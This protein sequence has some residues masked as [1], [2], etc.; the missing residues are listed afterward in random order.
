MP[1]VSFLTLTRLSCE[2][3][4]TRQAS[5]QLPS[6]WLLLS[7]YTTTHGSTMTK[8]LGLPGISLQ[9]E[10]CTQCGETLGESMAMRLAHVL[11]I[12]SLFPFPFP[13]L[14]FRVFQLPVFLLRGLSAPCSLVFF[15]CEVT[16]PFS[17]HF[18]LVRS[19]CSTS[20]S[21]FW[22]IS[23]LQRLLKSSLQKLVGCL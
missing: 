13:F 15:H 5:N 20:S 3:G 11:H 17:L 9:I 2:S 10:E 12:F 14:R 6:T 16:C 18:L 21:R 4:S 22:A 19:V 7:R 23:N 8:R 1:V